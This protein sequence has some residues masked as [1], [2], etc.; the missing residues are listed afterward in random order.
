[1]I[2]PLESLSF[3]M[4]G[5]PGLYAL[6]LGSGVSRAAQIP[7]GWEITCDLTR[8]LAKLREAPPETDP[9]DWYRRTFD[10][11]PDYSDLL[12]T[13]FKKPPERQQALKKY[14][15]P[16][17]GDEEGV[18]QLPRRTGPL[19]GWPGRGSSK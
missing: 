14:F 13:L 9:E 4:Q 16:N 5:N 18:K 2:T 3:S 6:L 1:M 12:E 11:P 19:R 17:D 10:K 8:Q 7:T 15:E